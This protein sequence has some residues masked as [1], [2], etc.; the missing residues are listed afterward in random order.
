[1]K[2]KEQT[3]HKLEVVTVRLLREGKNYH[4]HDTVVPPILFKYK[5]SPHTKRQFSTGC[6]HI[7]F[8]T[9]IFSTAGRKKNQTYI[10]KNTCTNKSRTSL[11]T[12][13]FLCNSWAFISFNYIH[14]FVH[15]CNTI[16]SSFGMIVSSR[17]SCIR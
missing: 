9:D 16:S 12:F 4:I 8:F 14:T 17:G 1:V 11:P 15:W 2:K 3:D 7:V 13:F 6:Y 5:E 10:I